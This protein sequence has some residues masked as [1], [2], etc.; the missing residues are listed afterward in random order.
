MLQLFKLGGMSRKKGGSN[1]LQFGFFSTCTGFPEVHRLGN[2]GQLAV[3]G[4]SHQ[5]PPKGVVKP[6][7]A[8]GP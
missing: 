7:V 4:T 1:G 2:E 3:G 6:D 8:E 5:A